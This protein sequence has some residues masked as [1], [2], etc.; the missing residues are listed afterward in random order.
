MQLLKDNLRLVRVVLLTRQWRKVLRLTMVLVMLFIH[1]RGKARGKVKIDKRPDSWRYGAHYQK[2]PSHSFKRH[3]VT[4]VILFF[5]TYVCLLHC[6]FLWFSIECWNVRFWVTFPWQWDFRISMSY[7]N[8]ENESCL[9]SRCYSQ[10]QYNNHL[11]YD[12]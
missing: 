1:I 2:V 10:T 12:I 7:Y 6:H 8:L 9:A 11:Q 4:I 5:H 3:S